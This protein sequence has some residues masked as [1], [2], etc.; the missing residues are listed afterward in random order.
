MCRQIVECVPNFSEGLNM[1]VVDAIVDAVSTVPG[2]L[3]LDRSSDVDH[4]R[5]VLTFAGYPEAVAEG[6]IRATQKAVERI[7]LNRHKGVHPRIGAADVIPFVPVANIDLNECVTL[8]WKVGQ[9]IWERLAVP[10]YFYG[11]AARVKERVG[12]AN[13][14]RGG[15][16]RLR[17]AVH[18]DPKRRPDL[19]G[20][21]LHP[22]AGAVAV[23]ARKWLIAYNINLETSDVELARTIAKTVRASSGGFPHVQA[24]GVFLASR[25]LAQVS[26][27]LTDFEQIPVDHLF[28]TVRREAEQRGGKI[29]GSEIVGLIPKRAFEMAPEFYM[30]CENFHPNL[31]LENRIAALRL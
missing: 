26:M 24:M 9:E 29:A 18:T 7:N 5:S 3:L 30:R 15:F 19:G 16:E 12:L 20:P 2:L 23:G 4:N 13:I 6:A 11:A 25:K 28:D 17:E 21:L 22:T 31:I 8:A 10:V 1:L 14:R 27:N